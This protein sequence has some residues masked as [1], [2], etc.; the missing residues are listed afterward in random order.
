MDRERGVTQLLLVYW[1]DAEGS[2]RWEKDAREWAQD[3]ESG[4]CITAGFV[5]AETGRY[6]TLAS[7]VHSGAFGGC[8]KIPVKM[9]HKREVIRTW[10]RKRKGS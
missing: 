1:H 9:I 8:W 6:L 3:D 7:A 5:V 2:E 4:L 10:P